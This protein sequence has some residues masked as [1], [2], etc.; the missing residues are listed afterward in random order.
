MSVTGNTFAPTINHTLYNNT[1]DASG[2]SCILLAGYT[3]VVTA[4]ELSRRTMRK[5]KM[6]FFWAL[7]YNTLGIPIA[8]LGLLRPELAGAAMA[9]SSVSVVSNSLLLRRFRPSLFRAAQ[10]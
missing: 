3:D 1:I 5:I 6:N 9:L 4:I 8:A 10:G 7:G 2:G